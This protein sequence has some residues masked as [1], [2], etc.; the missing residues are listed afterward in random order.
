MTEI[1]MREP[2]MNDQVE[3]AADGPMS[4]L[5]T[6]L[7]KFRAF[8]ALIVIMSL[9][10]FL[11]PSFLTWS[12]LVTVLVQASINGL[13][14]IGMTLVIISGGIDLSVGAIAGLCGMV[15]GALIDVGIPIHALGVTLYP[16]AWVVVVVGIAAGACVGAINGWIITRLKVAP[17]IAT[18]GTLY[19]ARGFALLSNNG[20]T[21]PFLDGTAERG[22][23]G[24]PWLG[25]GLFLDIPVPIWLLAIATVLAIG[26]ANRTTF[27]RHV[28]AVGGNERAAALSG[29]RVRKVRARV[30]VISGG[31]AALAGIVIAAQLDSANASAGTGYELNA[32]AAAVLGGTSL[33]GGKGT[34]S[35]SVIGA[36]VIA[37]LVDGLILL[38]VSDFWQMII[39][40][41]VIVA[42]VAID[43]VEFN[44]VRFPWRKRRGEAA[45]SRV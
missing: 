3:G 30:Y 5:G 14:A 31:L 43:Q 33:M 38:G 44:T 40:G 36:L 15:V 17:F 39:T 1:S 13:L 20:S 22:N 28:Y 24:F 29:V 12:N 41:F 45:A 4:G 19:I 21:F 37:V 10:T 6:L 27:G 23:T 42:A 9:F 32:I 18:L 16:D 2:Q 34:V 25:N 35:G 26:L 7:L 8:V 11:S